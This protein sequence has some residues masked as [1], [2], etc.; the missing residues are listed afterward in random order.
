MRWRDI[1]TPTPIHI[2][3]LL[4]LS[5]GQQTDNSNRKHCTLQFSS[6]TTTL[7]VSEP[8]WEH[9]RSFSRCGAA[10]QSR[11][12]GL[13]TVPH[14]D[15]CHGFHPSEHKLPSQHSHCPNNS[16]KQ[17]QTLPRSLHAQRGDPGTARATVVAPEDGRAPPELRRRANR[18]QIRLPPTL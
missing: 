10:N 17:P 15:H 14:H 6:R 9:L 18:N 1:R 16:H 11:G 3:F 4:F 8:L 5:G 12:G 2:T 13:T 7:Q